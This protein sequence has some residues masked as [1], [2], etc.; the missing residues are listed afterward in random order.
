MYE[1]ITYQKKKL[2]QYL[3][4]IKN[5]KKITIDIIISLI[6]FILLIVNYKAQSKIK[7]NLYLCTRVFIL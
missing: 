3:Y 2:Q 4:G 5:I 6:F 7:L 1:L